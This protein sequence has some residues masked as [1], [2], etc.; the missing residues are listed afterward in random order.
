MADNL[1]IKDGSGNPVVKATKDI[2]AGVQLEK[3]LLA[4]AA[5]APL[6]ALP[7]TLPADQSVSIEGTV[8]VSIAG[9]VA[10]SGNIAAAARLLDDTGATAVPKFA[11][12]SAAAS[13]ATSVVAAVTGKRIRVL[14]YVFMAAAAGTVLFRGTVTALTGAFP[15]VAN[16]GVASAASPMG[17]FQT[18][19][20]EA[21]NIVLSAAFAVGGHVVYI[22]V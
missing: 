16:S 3:V 14:G 12:I 6:A 17:Q 8:P 15:V 9:T 2:G 10:V 5:G 22:E 4:D 20:G 18:P 19:V 13:G 7:V 11:P 1:N 21:L